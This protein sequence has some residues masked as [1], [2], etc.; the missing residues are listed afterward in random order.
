MDALYL[1]GCPYHRIT[2]RISPHNAYTNTAALIACLPKRGYP[3]TYQKL[4]T[5]PFKE[6]RC[7]TVAEV[8]LAIGFGPGIIPETEPCA[9]G[10]VL[11]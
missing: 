3:T 6:P 2:T 11:E 9:A 5:R 1:G 7:L 4:P 10:A 8:S